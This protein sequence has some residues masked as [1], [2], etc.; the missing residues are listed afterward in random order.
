M[1]IL[2]MGEIMNKELL[3]SIN[4]YLAN[5]AVEYFKLHNLHWN[6]IG[7]NFKSTHEY[8]EDYMME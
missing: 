1:S 4:K 6:V 3:S 7:I 8:L 2:I 5:L